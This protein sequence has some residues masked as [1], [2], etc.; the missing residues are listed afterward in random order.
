MKCGECGKW[1]PTLLHG[2]KPSRRSV[3]QDLKEKERLPAQETPK[4]NPATS[5][6]AN[7]NAST[8]ESTS[9][10]HAKEGN[11]ITAMFASVILRYKDRPNIETRVYA[12][13]DD[14][15][16]S[17]FV[18]D[19]VLKDLGVRGT[20]VSLRLNTMHG[21]TSVPVQRVDGLVVQ[22]LDKSENP[23]LLPKTYSREA[24]R[25][26]REQIPTPEVASK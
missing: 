24:I 8:C 7:T 13:L 1:H 15:S 16:D 11:V 5:E 9:S 17:T 20:E 25:S 22:T 12:L 2:I 6:S 14:G 26:R 23:I 4:E 18:K 10:N 21:Q 3:K 19:S